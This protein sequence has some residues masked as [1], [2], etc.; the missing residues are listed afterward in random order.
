MPQ[1]DRNRENESRKTK[2]EKTDEKSVSFLSQ[3]EAYELLSIAYD[4]VIES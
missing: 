3:I 2:I 1:T 4:I